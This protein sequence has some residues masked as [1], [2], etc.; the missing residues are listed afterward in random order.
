VPIF[1]RVLVEDV[2]VGKW[3]CSLSYCF[4]DRQ[5][6]NKNLQF[7]FPG[8]YI[9]LINTPVRKYVPDVTNLAFV[10]ILFLIFMNYIHDVTVL[11]GLWQ[12]QEIKAWVSDD[13]TIED[14]PR[15]C[16]SSWEF[17]SVV[18]IWVF[19][20]GF[21][22]VVSSFGLPSASDKWLQIFRL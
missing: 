16:A 21:H 3:T 2:S 18:S 7:Q 1:G 11:Y 17:S 14:S 6:R 22:I 8:W 9:T 4:S 20:A 5:S 13:V 15:G 10:R 19:V 12:I